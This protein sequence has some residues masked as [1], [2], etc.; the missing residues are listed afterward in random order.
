MTD[1][2]E[3]RPAGRYEWEQ[4]IRRARLGALVTGSGRIGRSGKVTRGGMTELTFTAIALC[5]AS[6]ADDKGRDIWAGD[7]TVAVDL[8][9]SI[10]NVVTVRKKLLE[11]GLLE[12]VRGRR[13]DR[14]EEYRLTLSSDLFDLVE[15][16]SPAQHKLAARRLRDE[17][18]GKP[19]G[20]GGPP[21]PEPL[22]NPVDHP[23]PVDN[24]SVGGPVDHPQPTDLVKAGGSGGPA[25]MAS[26][27]S[28]GPA[29]GGPADPLTDHYRTSTTTDHPER[30]LRTAVTVPRE[31]GA[32][33]QPDSPIAAEPPT[34]PRPAVGRHRARASPPDHCDRHPVMPGGTDRTGRPACSSCRAQARAP[35]PNPP[36][37]RPELRV[38]QGGQ[39]A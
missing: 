32:A 30:D 22:G 11:L 7:A 3:I 14:G 26:G 36:D 10:K 13:A 23:G 34:D 29:L 19:G 6:Y 2:R 33:T 20:S 27:G 16:P 21:E 5:W 17:A 4:I 31:P 37:A 38:V 1:D 24:S 9:T 8:G 25:E 39:A 28:G 35:D 15:V 12:H 18:R